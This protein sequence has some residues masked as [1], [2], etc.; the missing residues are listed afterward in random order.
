MSPVSVISMLQK[1][2]NSPISPFHESPAE[3]PKRHNLL[4]NCTKKYKI[5]VNVFI[6]SGII[7]WTVF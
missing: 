6:L 2:A 1:P 5:L 4:V 7:Q 3:K